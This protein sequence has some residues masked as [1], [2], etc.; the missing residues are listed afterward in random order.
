MRPSVSHSLIGTLKYLPLVL[1]L[2]A[3]EAAATRCFEYR[4]IPETIDCSA[5]GSNSADFSSDCKHVKP[6]QE[7]EEI[8]CPFRWVNTDGSKTHAQVC[9][10]VGLNTTSVGGEICSSGERRA[11]DTYNFIYGKWG[12]VSSG[13]TSTTT[14]NGKYY[15]WA[16][17]QKKDYDRT[18]IVT[19][20]P[21]GGE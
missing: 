18:D 8:V 11:P 5:N 19:A 12:G 7:V 14:R 4:D 3:S 17:R 6:V 16:S 20:Y 21:C 2:T 1:V 15:C 10:S 13:G 9:Q